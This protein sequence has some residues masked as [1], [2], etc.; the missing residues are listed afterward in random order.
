MLASLVLARRSS[1]LALRI[2]ERV[3]ERLGS[4]LPLG[5]ACPFHLRVILCIQT[6]VSKFDEMNEI[7]HIQFSRMVNV[8]LLRIDFIQT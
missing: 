6:I 4:G 2:S 8:G 5:G 1:K 7:W 3:R